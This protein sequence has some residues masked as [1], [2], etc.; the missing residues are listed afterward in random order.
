MMRLDGLTPE[1]RQAVLTDIDEIQAG[2]NGV[3]SLLLVVL[4]VVLILKLMD[5]EIVIK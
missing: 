2:G 5:K 4:L 3:V 1:E